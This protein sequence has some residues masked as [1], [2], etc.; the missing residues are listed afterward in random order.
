MTTLPALP[1]LAAIMPEIIILVAAL[2]VL[3]MDFMMPKVNK[4]YLAFLSALGL[5][6]AGILSYQTL[7]QNLPTEIMGLSAD[8]YAQFFKIIFCIAGVM[9]MGISVRFLDLEGYHYGEYYAIILFAILGQMIMASGTNLM[10]IYV[11]LELMALSL[12]VLAGLFKKNPKSNEAS[13][14]YFLLGAFSSGFFLYGIMMTYGL[15]GSLDL[16]VI[17]EKVTAG[18]FSGLLLLAVVTMATG[19]AFKIAAAPFHFWSPDVYEGSPTSVTAFMSVGPKAAAFAAL[20]R[21]FTVACGPIRLEWVTLFIC[22]S[23]ATMVTGNFIALRQTNIKRMLAYSSIAHAGYLMIGLIVGGEIGTSSVLLYLLVYTFMNIGAFGVVILLNRVGGV[24][25]HIDD[26]T[27]LARVSRASAFVMLVFMFSLAGIPPTAGFA[28][29]FY[30]F[31]GAVKAGYVWLAVIGVLNSAVSAYYYLR[32]IMRMYMSEPDKVKEPVLN[33]STAMS[34]ILFAAVVAVLVIGIFP[35][36]F[37][38]LAISSV[39]SIL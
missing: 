3:T 33:T 18:H 10:V 24:G 7:S 6:I 15:T 8:S 17:A 32:I 14:K 31:M 12:Y 27:G 23:I 19:F 4:G 34:A 26:F 25:D 5:V 21:V 22:L 1:N 16:S 30:L 11:G 20:L 29:K 9:V 28:G 39:G 35:E 13:V 36:F 38:N 2:T 37:L